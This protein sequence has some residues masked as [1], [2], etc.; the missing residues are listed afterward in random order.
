MIHFRAIWPLHP[1]AADLLS[2][3][4]CLIAVEGNPSGQFAKLIR[5]ETG[6]KVDGLILKYDGLPFSAGC[7]LNEV[8]VKRGA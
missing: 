2:Q 7:I 6:R 4:K 8:K 5:R 1:K 3:M